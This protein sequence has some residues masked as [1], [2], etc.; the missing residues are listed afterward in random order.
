M[1]HSLRP[2][3]ASGQTFIVPGVGDALGAVLVKEAGF[4]CLYMSGYYVSACLGYLDVGLISSTEM[5][6][7][8]AR[9]CAAADMPVLA[10]ADTGYGNALNVIRTVREF[11]AAGVAGMHLEDQDLPKKSGHMEGLKLVAPKEMCAKIQAAVDARASD[12]FLVI[13]RTDAIATGGMEEA[14]R[15]ANEYRRAGADAAMIMAPRSIDDLKK[16]R[17][18]VQG[19][20]AVTVGSWSFNV[21]KPELERI[22]Y[23]F[24]L[25]TVSTLRR[26]IV[27][28]RE[29]LAKL[30]QDGGL[31]HSAPAMISM[32]DMHRLLG[33]E[34]VKEWEK[35]YGAG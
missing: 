29:V 11:E 28:T 33:Q 20:L 22:G 19:P 14:V 26:M 6:A 27:V 7:Q 8:A 13:A 34:Q 21:T 17:D 10:D 35:R 2:L 9:I 16:F 3:L 4:P 25:F 24:A 18:G 23:Q 15:R 1:K 5:I 31:D 12:D 30:K 32:N